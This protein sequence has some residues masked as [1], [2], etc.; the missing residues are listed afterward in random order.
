M[1]V[2]ASDSEVVVAEIALSN[3][4]VNEESEIIKQSNNKPD[5]SYLVS[6]TRDDHRQNLLIIFF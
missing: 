6:S 2:P 4:E 1:I 5:N 3:E